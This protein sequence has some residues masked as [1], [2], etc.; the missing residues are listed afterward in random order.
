MDHEELYLIQK[1][2]TELFRELFSLKNM[3]R[4]IM[5][6]ICD[7]NIVFEEIKKLCLE[8]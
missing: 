5:D 3:Y 2:L 8:Q 1:Q 4:D 7:Q 6:S